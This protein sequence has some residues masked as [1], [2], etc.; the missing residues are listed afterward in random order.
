VIL[1]RPITDWLIGSL[2]YEYT[3]N[4]ANVEVF[5]YD[6]HV[7]GGYLTLYYQPDL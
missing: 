3:N 5:D 4:D 1:E 6:R 2:R 7:V